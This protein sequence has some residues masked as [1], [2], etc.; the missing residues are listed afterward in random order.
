MEIAL[1]RPATA[2][3]GH[4]CTLVPGDPVW[5][6]EAAVGA[7]A[8]ILPQATLGHAGRVHQRRQPGRRG[9]NIPG[10]LHEQVVWVLTKLRN[11]FGYLKSFKTLGF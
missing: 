8:S 11:T 2:L 10:A 5:R 3:H 1:T 4:R 9:Q 7:G 6:R